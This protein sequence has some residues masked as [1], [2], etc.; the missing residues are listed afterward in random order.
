MKIKFVD[1]LYWVL[2]FLPLVVTGAVYQDFPL[3]I[4]AH[5]NALW[6]VDRYGSREELFIFPSVIIVIAAFF[7]LFFMLI[8][9][10]TNGQNEKIVQ[11]SKLIVIV[12]FAV[13]SIVILIVIYRSAKAQAVPDFYKIVAVLLSLGDI[14]MANYLP[15]CKRNGWTGIRT[16]FT[17]SSDEVWY[18]THR[19]GGWL[20]AIGGILCIAVSLLLEGIAC[21]MTV[22][23]AE[24]AMLAIVV[25]YSYRIS[26]KEDSA[27]E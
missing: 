7:W 26:K 4:P 8:N 21:L 22:C 12:T 5:F 13:I 17:L 20:I 14:V 3:T 24:I 10:S 25:F 18:K 6:Q 2:A 19:F 27:D 15:K 11:T 1:G 23:V 9:K 16:S